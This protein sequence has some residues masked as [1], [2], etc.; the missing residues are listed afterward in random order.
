MAGIYV[1]IPFCKS[2]C[3]YCGFFSTTLLERRQEYVDAV[4]EELSRRRHFLGNAP[5]E[6]IYFGGGTPSLLSEAELEKL[7]TS[8]DNIYNVR[9]GAEV[10][11]EGNPDDMT[12][13]LLSSLRGLGINRLSMGVHKRW[14]STM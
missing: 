6:T 1:H 13:T 10:T 8:I 12:R 7:L 14:G 4:V 2:R 11:L 5:V 9:E 3:I